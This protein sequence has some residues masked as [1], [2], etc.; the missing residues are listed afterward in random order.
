MSSADLERCVGGAI[1][2]PC[3]LV[4]Y[5]PPTRRPERGAAELEAI[6]AACDALPSVVVTFPGADP[7]ASEIVD[8]LRRWSSAR[9]G[10]HLVPSL[11]PAYAAMLARADVVVGNSSSGIV[12]APT[13]GVPVVNVGDRQRGRE[14]G[15]GVIDVPGEPAAV[16]RAME[17][18]LDPAFR[19]RVE[20]IP[21]PY[22]DGRAAPRIVEV[23][24][25]C[26]LA[27]LLHKRFVEAEDR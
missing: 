12:E 18:A 25:S 3:G 14:R 26:D 2:A 13:F 21:N 23:V 24:A 10:V 9:P 8:R 1:T 19:R 16:R 17:Q 11:G 15:A 4:T 20:G 27:P 5:H 22:G 6:I 7:G